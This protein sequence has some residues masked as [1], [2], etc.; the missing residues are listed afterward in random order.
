MSYKLTFRFIVVVC[1]AVICTLGLS[2]SGADPQLPTAGLST[3]VFNTCAGAECENVQVDQIVVHTDGKVYFDTSGVESALTSC[4]PLAGI[5]IEILP[6]QNNFKEMYTAL[7]AQQLSNKTVSLNLSGG[8]GGV[9]CVA[10]W[11]TV[12]RSP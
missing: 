5:W 8:V 6:T 11:V 10:N 2:Q 12:V 1:L 4:T 7:L 3:Q 9:G